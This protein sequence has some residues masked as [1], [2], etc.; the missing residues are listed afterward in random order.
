MG[1]YHFGFQR[2]LSNTWPNSG[3]IKEEVFFIMEE[4]DR[5]WGS[6]LPSGCEESQEIEKNMFVTADMSDMEDTGRELEATIH[7]EKEDGEEEDRSIQCAD[8]DDSSS[9]GGPVGNA[10]PPANAG[11]AATN[12]TSAAPAERAANSTPTNVVGSTLVVPRNVP[13]ARARSRSPTPRSRALSASSDI[14]SNNGGNSSINSLIQVTLLQM[15]EDRQQRITQQN[16]QREREVRMER[17]R[18]AD[19]RMREMEMRESRQ[20]RQT[21]MMAMMGGRL[22]PTATNPSQEEKDETKEDK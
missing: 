13:A 5:N 8:E 6:I 3:G 14:S 4:E 22:P 21:M 10:A 20:F 9:R 17:E 1:A 19:R 12:L 2:T 18:E 16:E 11:A 7:E 15:Q